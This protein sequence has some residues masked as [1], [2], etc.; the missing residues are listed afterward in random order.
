MT[1]DVKFFAADMAGAPQVSGSRGSLLAVIDAC[2][3]TG[4][5][6]VSVT[7]AVAAG[8]AT[9]VRSSGNFV[10]DQVVLIED[11]PRRHQPPVT[12]INCTGT[13]L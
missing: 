2:L 5:G 1:T 7:V 12:A 3:V 11:H 13:R 10:A 9:V 8:V 6:L 4:F